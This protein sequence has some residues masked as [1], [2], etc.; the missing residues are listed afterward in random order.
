MDARDSGEWAEK[1]F[2]AQE[3]GGSVAF[4]FYCQSRDGTFSHDQLY[5]VWEPQDVAALI[6]RLQVSAPPAVAPE[7]NP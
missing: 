3:S 6:Q 1:L 2:E 7:Q 5:A 4:D